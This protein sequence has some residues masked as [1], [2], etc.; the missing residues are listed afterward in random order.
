MKTRTITLFS[1]HVLEV[2]Q[3]IQRIDSSSTHGWQVRYGG[4]KFFSDGS[5]DGSGAQASLQAATKE[6]MRRIA[7]LPAPVRVKQDT[8]LSNKGS[9]LPPGISGPIV[10]SRRGEQF[11]SAVLSVVLPRF[12]GTPQIRSVYIGTENTY[13]KQRFREALARAIELRTEAVTRYQAEATKAKRR[14]AKAMVA[15]LAAARQAAATR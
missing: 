6:L 14:D 4:T 2:P 12:G 5:A 9:T 3:N 13:T 8:P 10:K 15:T 11:R 7:T 1:G